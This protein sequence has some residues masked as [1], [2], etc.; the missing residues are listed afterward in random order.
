LGESSHVKFSSKGYCGTWVDNLTIVIMETLQ[1]GGGL[2]YTF[3]A[4]F[5]FC[6]GANKVSTFEGTKIGVIKQIN[7]NY[8]PFS[9]GV[10]CMAHGC[11]MV[12]YLPWE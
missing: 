6:F 8:V 5:F 1:K 11:N 2:S 7:T 4:E 10:H 3:I 9:I 12:P